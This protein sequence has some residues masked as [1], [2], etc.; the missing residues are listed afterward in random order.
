[1]ISLH[2]TTLLNGR[3]FEMLVGWGAKTSL[4]SPYYKPKYNGKLRNSAHYA[5]AVGFK[6]LQ[7][8]WWNKTGSEGRDYRQ[9]WIN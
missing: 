1:M 4:I 6:H 9:E 7:Y 2:N 3:E 5:A 8:D